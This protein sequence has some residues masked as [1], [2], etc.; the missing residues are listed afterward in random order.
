MTSRLK[1]M[2]MKTLNWHAR[3]RPWLALRFAAQSPITPPTTPPS[4]APPWKHE[5]ASEAPRF[6]KPMSCR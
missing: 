1:G 2:P 6:E 5:T 3:M 4:A